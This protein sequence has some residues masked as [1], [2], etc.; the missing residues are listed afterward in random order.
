[1]NAVATHLWHPPAEKKIHLQKNKRSC[2]IGR[3]INKKIISITI[4]IERNKMHIKRKINIFLD[5][6]NII[7]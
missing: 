1:M 6:E 5:I 4:F 2:Q 3:K 7:D